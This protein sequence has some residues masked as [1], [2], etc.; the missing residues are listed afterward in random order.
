MEVTLR[1]YLVIGNDLIGQVKCKEML[2]LSIYLGPRPSGVLERGLQGCGIGPNILKNLKI[3]K[4]FMI[5][6][7]QTYYY[8]L[9]QVRVVRA[10]QITTFL[11]PNQEATA[12]IL[13]DS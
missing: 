5:F 6:V 4:Y 13:Y 8:G 7:L 10:F 11:P 3:A 9:N 2:L 12:R 1:T